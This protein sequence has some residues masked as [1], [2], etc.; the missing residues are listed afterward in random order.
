MEHPQSPSAAPDLAFAGALLPV[1][2]HRIRNT[3]QLVTGVNAV[4]AYEEPGGPLPEARAGD[5][6]QAAREADELGW[7]L[8]VLSGGLGADLCGGR[9]EPRGLALTLELVREALRRTGGS[10]GLPSPAAPELAPGAPAAALCL[11]VA[12]LCWSAGRGSAGP[13]LGF[14]RTPEGWDVWLR[15]GACEAGPGPAGRLAEARLELQSEA[16]GAGWRLRL[17]AAWL[18]AG[19][20]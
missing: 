8:G 20:I 9:G 16:D 2:L 6:A 3:T 11:T 17:P 15:G 4:L 14:E 10:L 7:L 5:L 1:L 13:E 18:V 12:E 19:P